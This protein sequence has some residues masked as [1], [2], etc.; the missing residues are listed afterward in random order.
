MFCRN[1]NVEVTADEFL[2]MRCPE[3]DAFAGNP[4]S[5]VNIGQLCVQILNDRG[6]YTQSEVVELKDIYGLNVE[7][8]HYCEHWREVVVQ[9]EGCTEDV[10]R[11]CGQRCCRHSWCPDCIH[12][13]SVCD[14]YCCSQCCTVCDGCN[15]TLCDNCDCSCSDCNNYHGCSSCL[16]SHRD[17]EHSPDEEAEVEAEVEAPPPDLYAYKFFR[18]DQENP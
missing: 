6:S 11:D 18:D 7:W 10:C 15:E 17:A 9:C 12:T 14:S 13:C 4:L 2:P 3:C 16:E 5:D 8:C 1:C